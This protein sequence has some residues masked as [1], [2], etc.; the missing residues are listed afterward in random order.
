M[1]ERSQAL[2]ALQSNEFDLLVVGG[3]AT[4]AG[5]ALDAATRGFSV[6]LIERADYA[7]GT[8]SRSSKLVHGGLRYLQSFDLGLVRE[9]LLE[10]QLMVA[11]APHLV[12]PLPLVVPAFDGARPDRLVGVGLNLYDVMSVDRGRLRSRRSRRA[13]AQSQL[14]EGQG[15]SWSPERHRV[16]GG[17]EVVEMI[18]ALA[19]RAP[20]SG[21]LFYDCQTDDSR[22]VLTI[23]G[24]AERFGAVCANRLAAQSLLEEDG[25][26]CGVLAKD[27][28]SG[29]ELAVRA[30]SVVNATG[31]WADEL[32]PQELHDEAELPSI[33]P[34]RGTHITLASSDL[35][36]VAGAIV[37]AGGGRSIFAL[38]WL[39]RTL[40][41][42]TDNDYE[43][44]LAH[45][46]PSEQDV[47]YLLRAVNEFFATE[48]TPGELTG[49]YAGVRPL[50]S[51]GDTRKS[52]DIS[53]KAELY[54]TSSGM[55]T[56]TG[57]K[58][59]TWRRMAKMTVDRL[60]ER[61]ARD[62][63]CRTHEIPL[64]QQIS[65]DELPRLPGVP[66][67]SYAALAARYGHAAHD[68]LALA[69][70]DPLLAAPI[71]PDMPD[72]LAEAALAAAREQ[73][74]SVGDVLLRRT[75]LGLLAARQ[76]HARAGRPGGRR[77]GR[78]S[79]LGRGA[80][81]GRDRPLRAGGAG[82]GDRLRRLTRY[83]AWRKRVPVA[84]STRPDA[85]RP[86]TPQRENNMAVLD[87]SDLEASPLADL[88]AIA[89]E[90]GLDGYRR[91]RKGDLI[92]RILERGGG[93]E[94]QQTSEDGEGDEA[95]PSPS[96]R[97]RRAPRRRRAARED[98]EPREPEP[99]PESE[100][101]A[102]SR[103]RRR[104]GEEGEQPRRRAGR[105]RRS[106]EPEEAREP[107][108]EAGG[109]QD[110]ES[111]V[112]GVVEV[113][114]NGSA[115]LRPDASLDLD[116]DVYVSAAQVRRCELE[117]GDRVS[118]PMRAPR[119]SERHPSL[120]RVESINGEPADAV[121]G[122]PK[123]DS[124][125]AAFPR[126]RLQ[127]GSED[128][129]L[130]AIEWLTPIGRGSRV[131]IVGA[132]RA[133][134]TE[135]LRA[136][137][138]ALRDQEGLQISLVLAGVRPEE[139]ADWQA[140]EPA[141]VA[142]LAASPDAQGQ[143]IE[144]AVESAKRLAGRGEHVLLAIDCLDGVAPHV[145]RRALAAARNIVDGG[146]LTVIA[147]AAEAFGGE[148]TVIA[149]DALRTSTGRLPALDLLA[150]GTLKAEL[151][152]GE[153]SAAE[154]VRVRAEAAAA[155]G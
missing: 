109:E 33:R 136:L 93:A 68:V 24:E 1:I 54:E 12:R 81:R 118:G 20:T 48:L 119:G 31:V 30:G 88:H 103:R 147:T 62:A 77:D 125:P 32:R 58:L 134:K 18:P 70:A 6:A 15:A 135:T 53:R 83:P 128:S 124:L 82:G 120:V 16:I 76:T 98:E 126:E 72:L 14:F 138:G 2:S 10:R 34:S 9:A 116:G 46:Q 64:G 100:P 43:G 63:P 25:R 153:E 17:E 69:Q 59:T 129:T 57:G 152:V 101:A 145:A 112:E 84:A 142:T 49:A 110:R 146:S 140:S 41:G 47:E 37:P 56:I 143:A 99:E 39:G 11:L 66:E 91:L 19:A 3:G 28:E 141:A 35:P 85:N 111:A 67:E 44:A 148:T 27:M 127:L 107:A 144:R 45:V 114:A 5:V 74:R 108:A 105:S 139:V 8:S 151:L 78:A 121:V 7:S 92:E 155:L 26:A 75:R 55:I 131:A 29:A 21:Y 89:G 123:F 90:L 102:S 150:S 36:L 115:F 23:L 61:E 130:K 113:L 50:I 133:G 22:L 80:D 73:A 149:L 4:G 117:S 104:G 132:A 38:P 95:A 71:V 154:I 94:P 97:R 52:V 42:T 40:I 86:S 106:A 65:A 137:L 87:R 51:T 13:G 96:A 79:R 60:V 122:K